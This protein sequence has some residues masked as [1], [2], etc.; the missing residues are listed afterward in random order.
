MKK[1]EKNTKKIK[2][3]INKICISFFIISMSYIIYFCF[4]GY[5]EKSKYENI[6]N[7]IPISPAEIDETN[8]ERMLQ[9]AELRKQNS[10]IMG[11]LEIPKTDISYPVLQTKDNEYYLN[12]DYKRE[13]SKEGSLF[14]DKAYDFSIPSTNLLI[15]GHRN[16]KGI[17]F[18]NLIKY[19]T[20]EYYQ[21]HQNITFTT[22]K[23][24]SN[25]EII[26]VFYSKVYN[27]NDT[28]VFRY[29]Y[30]INAEN[31]SQFNEFIN[32]AKKASIYDTKKTAQYG[33]QLLTLS[34]CEYSQEDGRFVVVAKKINK[35][36]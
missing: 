14:I 35:N 28:N 36:N 15:Y 32:Q 2:S 30:F 19:K 7:E 34:T 25:Y 31:E 11:W 17:M 8:T 9:V 5:K 27:Q 10:E 12:H 13:N 4:S 20:E 3:I 16:S 18:E 21:E 1:R 23:E 6:L 29:Y 33:D 22:E 26:S 24:E